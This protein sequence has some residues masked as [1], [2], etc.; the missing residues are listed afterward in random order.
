MIN[1]L[2]GQFD[3]CEGVF[4]LSVSETEVESGMVLC[5]DS[6]TEIKIFRGLE[7]DNQP[8]G[9]SGDDYDATDYDAKNLPELARRKISI[10][11]G[12]MWIETDQF[13][14]EQSY[15]GG[16]PLYADT[17]SDGISYGQLTTAL[18]QYHQKELGVVV[19][20]NPGRGLLICSLKV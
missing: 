18:P 13:D 10:Y 5:L 1:I 12:S 8:F 4:D 11:R 2:D 7:T 15:A 19:S 20:H 6:N 14:E 16:T 17:G 3:I 9:L